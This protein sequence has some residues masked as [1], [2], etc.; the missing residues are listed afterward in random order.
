MAKYKLL[1]KV[2]YRKKTEKKI[3]KGITGFTSRTWTKKSANE[4]ISPIK[5][6]TEKALFAEKTLLYPV[7]HQE[8]I[9]K[10]YVENRI[11]NETI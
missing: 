6:E 1:F 10:E 8:K 9:F 5:Q 4:W 11:G 3:G 7:V 2:K